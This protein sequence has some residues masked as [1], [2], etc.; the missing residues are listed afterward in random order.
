MH[1]PVELQ[2]RILLAYG[3][4]VVSDDAVRSWAEVDK[5]LMV[6]DHVVSDDPVFNLPA[7]LPKLVFD[8]SA[9]S[10]RRVVMDQQTVGALCAYVNFDRATVPRVVL[11]WPDVVLDEIIGDLVVARLKTDGDRAPPFVG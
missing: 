11:T 1:E 2:G 9:V 5:P 3:Y 8:E 4:R 6:A 10:D 7:Q